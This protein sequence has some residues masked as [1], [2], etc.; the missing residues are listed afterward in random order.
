MTTH[1]Y[2]LTISVGKALLRISQN[3]NQGVS[4]AGSHIEAQLEKNLLP[5]SLRLL[6]E[7]ISLWLSRG[8]SFLLVVIW[9]PPSVPRGFTQLLAAALSLFRLPEVVCYVDFPKMTTSSIQQGVSRASL[10]NQTMPCI[11]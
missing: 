11:M 1:I 10:V 7:Y 8:P 5:S 6:A 9:R 4:H 2:H 3:W